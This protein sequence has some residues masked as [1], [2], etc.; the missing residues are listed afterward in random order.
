MGVQGLTVKGASKTTAQLN[1]SYWGEMWYSVKMVPEGEHW[2]TGEFS[3]PYKGELGK[4]LVM[5]QFH[6][7]EPSMKFMKQY[8]GKTDHKLRVSCLGSEHDMTMRIIGNPDHGYNVYIGSDEP[9]R[10][11]EQSSVRF[12][13]LFGTVSVTLSFEQ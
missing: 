5:V 4:Y 12:N 3:D 11:E 10:V 8:S 1:F 13:R 9:F 2:V 7:A 6:D